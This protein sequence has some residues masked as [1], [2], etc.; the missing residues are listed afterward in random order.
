MATADGDR[1]TVVLVG[2][3]GLTLS[4]LRRELAGY[5]W[6]SVTA[7]AADALAD[8]MPAGRL[9]VLFDSATVTV[10]DVTRELPDGRDVVACLAL[11]TRP[12]RS[13]VYAVSLLARDVS[14]PELA[15]LVRELAATRG[16]RY[17][18]VPI[19][20]DLTRSQP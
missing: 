7:I 19:G 4:F 12:P 13:D 20:R 5:A 6:L 1:V 15:R 18:I 14:P 11:Q 17:S 8:A 16:A 10:Y 9:V 3:D 2:L